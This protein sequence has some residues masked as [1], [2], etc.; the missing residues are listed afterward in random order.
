MSLFQETA[1][2]IIC[3]PKSHRDVVE[4]W[5]RQRAMQAVEVGPLD[6]CFSAR[7]VP[8]FPFNRTFEQA[9]WEP[10]VVL[11]TSGTT[12]IP[13]PVVIT[14]VSR[15]NATGAYLWLTPSFE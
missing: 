2:R 6:G 4:P 15:T 1:C 13:K 10:L 12:G 14:Q 5:L 3:F 9:E 11:H 7:E 8:H